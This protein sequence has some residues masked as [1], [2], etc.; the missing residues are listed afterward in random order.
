MCARV[1]ATLRGCLIA[2]AGDIARRS[3]SEFAVSRSA[4]TRWIR[5]SVAR[6]YCQRDFVSGHG[7]NAIALRGFPT[8][9]C[10]QRASILTAAAEF[11]NA[12]NELCSMSN[13]NEIIQ[14]PA[15]DTFKAL[16]YQ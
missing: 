3:N 16:P 1:V 14:W 7:E 10:L 12:E 5:L 8:H 11:Y 4:W 13:V 9:V 6:C 15:R 2:C